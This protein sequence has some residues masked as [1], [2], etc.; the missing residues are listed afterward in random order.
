M[1]NWICSSVEVLFLQYHVIW[2]KL[3]Q[4]NISTYKTNRYADNLGKICMM[5]KFRSISLQFITSLFFS[6][7]PL[8]FWYRCKLLESII[9]CATCL[10]YTG[11]RSWSFLPKLWTSKASDGVQA[12]TSVHS[13]LTT[14]QISYLES[15]ILHFKGPVELKMQFFL[16][17]SKILSFYI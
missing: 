6:K 8:L 7:L 14:F 10:P 1:S 16:A 4:P 11:T 3:R 5:C 12:V 13:I 17:H 2:K 9:V 15:F